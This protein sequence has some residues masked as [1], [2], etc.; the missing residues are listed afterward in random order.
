MTRT[1][2]VPEN[3]KTRMSLPAFENTADEVLASGEAIL[4]KSQAIVRE[5][6]EMKDEQISFASTLGQMD[7]LDFEE[8]EVL[9][10]IY[11]LQNVHPDPKIREACRS[12]ETKSRDW[13]LE[14]I[15]NESIYRK[16]KQFAE[17]PEAKT[18]EAEDKK[19]LTELLKDYKRLGMELPEEQKS[20]LKSLKKLLHKLEQ[21]FSRNIQ[22]Y[23]DE[24][25]VKQEELKG[26]DQSFI[27]GLQ[28]NS[29]NLYRISL[30]YPE[31]LPVM[32]HAESETLREQLLRKKY[33]T[34][35]KSNVELLQKMVDT[36][37]RL[38]Q[39]LGYESWNEFI[40]EKRMAK[41]P[42]K[43]FEFLKNLESHLKNKGDEEIKALT[44]LKQKHTGDSKAEL[45]IWDYYFYSSMWKKENYSIDSQKL[46][47]FFPLP[48]VLKGMFQVFN[49]I[50]G[51]E[52]QEERKGSFPSWHPDVELYKVSDDRKQDVGYF[53][54][55]LHPREGKYG[56]AAA[57]SLTHGKYLP[58]GEYQRPV[59]CMVCNFPRGTSERP[60]LISH[61]EVE[62]LFHEFGHILH[63]L[64]TQAKFFNFSGTSVAWD[65]VE[66]PSQVLE[67]WVWDFDSLQL[68]SRHYANENQKIDL[69]LVK[70]MNLAKKAGSA[71][72]YLRQVSLATA[73]MEIHRGTSEIDPIKTANQILE[74]VFL[75]P[76]ENTNFAAGW[77]HM[78]GYAS[79]YYGYAWADVMAA[80]LYSLFKKHGS[81]NKEWGRK[82]RKEIYEPGSSRDENESLERFLG[83]PLSSEAFFEE[84]GASS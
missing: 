4:K 14:K 72:F 58:N 2:S 83:R 40:I 80:D 70:R 68:I 50:F 44:S 26:L 18:L 62:T 37:L 76:P 77:G 21:D 55:D 81:L 75:A 17:T 79:G 66:A 36:R 59:S 28:K 56:H 13:H 25:W 24:L 49:Q 15:Y 84:L 52:I 42:E 6:A 69:E 9:S 57:F 22:E 31:Y 38:A 46:K 30:D 43:V 12:V 73:D 39:L 47:E 54:L 45:K 23:S 78:V 71:L 48:Q 7:D 74:K 20:E 34:A 33:N 3:V 41:K 16:V 27:D 63:N 65:F 35:A 60:P 32:E 29:Q 53:Y 51:L 1:G 19:L 5:L 67:N 10:R 11:L 82:L 61:S 64:M 8:S